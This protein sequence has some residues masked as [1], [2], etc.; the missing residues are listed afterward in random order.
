MRNNKVMPNGRQGFASVAVIGIIV[1]VVAIGISFGFY[2]FKNLRLDDIEER[3]VTIS[4]NNEVVAVL[5]ALSQDNCSV[6]DKWQL[7]SSANQDIVFKYPKHLTI[8]SN[9][10][11]KNSSITIFDKDSKE[12]PPIYISRISYNNIDITP[13]QFI[14]RKQQLVNSLSK[15]NRGVF[16]NDFIEL[17]GERSLLVVEESIGRPVDVPD[18]FFIN[19]YIPTKKNG[20]FLNIGARTPSA[21]EEMKKFVTN[22]KGITCSLDL[23]R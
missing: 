22:L 15:T 14:E 20:Y 18:D 11:L 2:Y 19:Y 3:K 9:M 1:L 13:A 8:S 17:G 4:Q 21:K 6:A 12:T 23:L 5:E 16:Y 7:F 10:E